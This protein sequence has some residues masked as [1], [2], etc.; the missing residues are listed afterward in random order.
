MLARISHQL[1]TA[2]PREKCGLAVLPM[3]GVGIGLTSV[4]IFYTIFLI[5]FV[6]WLKT[7]VVARPGDLSYGV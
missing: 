7:P 5:A 1:S 2:E 4:Y 3:N 6:P